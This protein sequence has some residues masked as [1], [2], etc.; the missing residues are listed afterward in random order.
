MTFPRRYHGHAHAGSCGHQ[1]WRP[2]SFCFHCV[3]QYTTPNTHTHTRSF[4]LKYVDRTT[5]VELLESGSVNP[6][7][8]TP[9]T[10]AD[11]QPAPELKARIEAWLSEHQGRG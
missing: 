5:A 4:T 11:I 3:F 2:G 9:L 1:P 8:R 10:A 7:T 6:F